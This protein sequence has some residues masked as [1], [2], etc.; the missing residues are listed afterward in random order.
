M[1]TSTLAIPIIKSLEVVPGLT[2]NEKICQLLYE[3]FSLNLQRCDG[4]IGRYEAKYGMVFEE[5]KLMWGRNE[6]PNRYSFEVER[7]YMEWEG[8]EYEKKIWIKRIKSLK[9]LQMDDIRE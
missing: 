5:F 6:V 1:E 2:V 9:S 3:N 4:E 8:L 7:D